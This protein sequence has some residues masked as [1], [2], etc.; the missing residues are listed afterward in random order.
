MA[1]HFNKLYRITIIKDNG[2][3]EYDK[4]HY[5]HYLLDYTISK[6]ERGDIYYIG[7][8]VWRVLYQVQNLKFLE[9]FQS[10]VMY[11]YIIIIFVAFY[12]I[13]VG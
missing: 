4:L 2:Y 7:H 8:K 5:R 1:G 13:Y 6:R 11:Y 3:V 9:E 12:V 10:Y